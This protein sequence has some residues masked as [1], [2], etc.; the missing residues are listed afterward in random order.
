[1]LG[2][3]LSGKE[4]KGVAHKTGADDHDSLALQIACLGQGAGGFGQWKR[5]TCLLP[6]EGGRNGE[7]VAVP[8]AVGIVTVC[9]AAIAQMSR[10]P[11]LNFVTFLPTW[12]TM[13]KSSWP[14][15]MG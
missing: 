2:A 12:T 5:K 6:A 7:I 8:F 1:M 14:K 4:N 10:S 11:N 13:P 15:A 3:K 9:I